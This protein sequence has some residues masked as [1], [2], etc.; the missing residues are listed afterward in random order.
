MKSVFKS[1]FVLLIITLVIRLLDVGKNLIIASKIGV[2]GLA[3][4]YNSLQALPDNMV[5]L[6]G[7]DTIKG[8]ANSEY[9]SLF[10]LGKH[11]EMRISLN[12]LFKYVIA[13]SGIF[14]IMVVLFR[15]EIIKLALPGLMDPI[16]L[17]ALSISIFIFPVFF[18]KSVSSVL[19]PYYNSRKKFYYPV[20]TQSL[21]AISIIIAVYVP[22]YNDNIVMN[23]S[24]AFLCGNII[25][26]LAILVPA[27]K[28][29]GFISINKLKPDPVTKMILVGC[30]AIFINSLMNQLYQSSRNFFASFFPEGSISAL[31]YGSTI[32]AFVGTLTFTIVF[33]V[34]LTNLSSLLSNNKK[35]EAKKLLF[36]TLSILYFIYIPIVITFLL[37]SDNILSLV[38]LRGKFDIEGIRLSQLPFRWETLTLLPFLSYIIPTSLLLAIKNYKYLTIAGAISFAAG[39]IFNLALSRSIGFYGVSIGAF[40]FSCLYGFLLL[41]KVYGIFGS[42]RKEMFVILRLLLCGIVTFAAMISFIV[43]FGLD[44]DT[45]SLIM[46]FFYIVLIWFAVSVFYITLTYLLVPQF[47]AFAIGFIKNK[48]GDMR[49][50]DRFF[51]ND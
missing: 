29:F 39:I 47:M 1:Y 24:I 26:F 6:L 4:V 51:K 42:I 32:P 21:I 15:S 5:I 10:A 22:Y 3:D 41:L 45:Q 31:T 40:I 28:D 34:L 44:F 33:G 19:L 18:I 12:I 23:L 30:S 48:I 16:F 13:V 11:S 37:L 38:F 36:D 46:N 49:F 9:S 7:I 25:Y 35:K 27:I 8:V 14:T 43:F 2:S 17:T 50:S 20:I